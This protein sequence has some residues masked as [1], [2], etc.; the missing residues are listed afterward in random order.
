ML[1]V[2]VGEK[3]A[4]VEELAINLRRRWPGVLRMAL[5]GSAPQGRH[6]K[7][8]IHALQPPCPTEFLS[9]INLNH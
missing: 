8:V 4:A 5:G 6:P 3:T 9:V 2:P 7:T 1:L